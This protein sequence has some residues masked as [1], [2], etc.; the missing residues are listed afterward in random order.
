MG[1]DFNYEGICWAGGAACFKLCKHTIP[2]IK[3]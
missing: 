2:V 3:F 1:I